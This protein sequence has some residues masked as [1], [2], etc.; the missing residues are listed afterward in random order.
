MHSDM[1]TQKVDI[2]I[3]LNDDEFDKL[4]EDEDAFYARASA[5]IGQ[6][7]N[8]EEHSCQSCDERADM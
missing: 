8:E 1:F 2:E 4:K 5:L 3:S 7:H 6:D